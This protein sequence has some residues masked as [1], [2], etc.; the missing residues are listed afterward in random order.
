M[1]PLTATATI[2]IQKDISDL[3]GMRTFKVIQG[4]IDKSNIKLQV[5][6]RPAGCAKKK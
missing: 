5:K 3:L 6:R 1:L 4:N 2:K